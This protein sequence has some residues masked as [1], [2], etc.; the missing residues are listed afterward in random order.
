[1]R[2]GNSP[3]WYNP[4]E[5]HMVKDYV[6]LLVHTRQNRCKPSEIGVVTPYHKQAQKIRQILRKHNFQDVTVGSV[7]EFQGSERRVI[8]ISTVRSSVE[9]L[10]FDNKHKLGFISNSK[11]FNVA[12]T[13]AQALLICIGNPYVLE[14]DKNWRSLL[15]LCR[16][17]G[18]YIGCDYTPTNNKNNNGSSSNNHDDIDDEIDETIA[19]LLKMDI[20]NDEMANDGSFQ[21]TSTKTEQENPEWRFEE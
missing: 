8:I 18:S 11:R 2:E 4:D 12:I 15:N 14:C 19:G 3:S 9:Y 20:E 21:Y 5:C 16:D 6:N 13:R 17:N 7:E 1:M 10:N